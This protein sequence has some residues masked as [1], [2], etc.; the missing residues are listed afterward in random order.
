MGVEEF[1]E[2]RS[3]LE[4]PTSTTTISSN[5]PTNGSTMLSH[6]GPTGDQLKLLLQSVL[7]NSSR[8]I[9]WPQSPTLITLSSTEWGMPSKGKD[10]SLKSQNIQKFIFKIIHTI[11]K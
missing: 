4:S 3:P 9:L 1:Q 2:V 6:P 10:F 7:T 11:I 8:S 5:L